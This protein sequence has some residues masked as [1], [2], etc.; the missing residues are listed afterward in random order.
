VSELTQAILGYLQSVESERLRW[1]A[2]PALACRVREVKRYQHARFT[3]TYQD[4]LDTP[5]SGKAARFFLDELYGPMDF[6]RRDAQF[7]RVAPKVATLFPGEVG[8]IVLSLARLHALSERLD[9]EMAAVVTVLPLSET[10]Y[11]CAWRAV[12]QPAARA[13]Q[14][15]LVQAVGLALAKQVRKPLIR[16]TLRMMRGPAKAAGLES[17][18]AFLEA[19]FDAFRDLPDAAEFVHAIATRETAIAAALFDGAEGAPASPWAAPSRTG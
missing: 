8:G 4:L 13:E 1:T 9:S 16:T 7:S 3:G 5:A 18:Q 6:S 11:Q 15:E 2:D 17:L 14:I 19:G 10:G 12:G